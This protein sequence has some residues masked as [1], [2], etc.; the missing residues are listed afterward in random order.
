M[1]RESDVSESS[2]VSDSPEDRKREEKASSYD[3]KDGLEE[4]IR[5]ILLDI[6]M[7]DDHKSQL[8]IFLDEKADEAYKLFSQIEELESQ[9]NKEQENCRRITSKIKKI[10]KAHGWYIK[11]QE[12]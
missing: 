7:L 10:I 11:A 5:Q 4:Q 6:E 9:I 8:E 2:E 1:N 3:D 12:E